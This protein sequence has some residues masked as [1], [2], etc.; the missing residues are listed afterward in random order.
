MSSKK[1]GLVIFLAIVSSI[2]AYILGQIDF[3]GFFDSRQGITIIRVLLS[4]VMTYLITIAVFLFDFTDRKHVFST[5]SG[6]AVFFTLFF[7]IASLHVVKT[8]FAGIFFLIFIDYIYMSSSSRLKLFINFRANDIF[9]PVVKK[10][11]FLLVILF[12]ILSFVQTQSLLT[13][14]NQLSP[15][16]IRLV[17]KPFVVIINKQ[18]ATQIGKQIDQIETQQP[19]NMSRPEI[20]KIALKQMVTH[21]DPERTKQLL[22]GISP[23]QIKIDK[24]IVREDAS[25]DLAPVVDD[26]IPTIANNINSKYGK[27]MVFTPLAIALVVILLLQSSLWPFTFIADF[28]TPFIFYILL[29]T[30]FIK[31]MTEKVDVERIVL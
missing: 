4:V 21:M 11:F 9:L 16:F 24:A 27:Y 30:G 7:Y 1:V 19:I 6:I 23:T 26:L 31:K 13:T 25:I 10:G 29:Q 22:F 2:F 15:L 3:Y 5:F 12:S 17:S 18:L 20:T 8:I 14:N 28:V